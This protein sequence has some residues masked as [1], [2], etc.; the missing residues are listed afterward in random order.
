MKI[1]KIIFISYFSV[2]GLSLL[3]LLI[4]SFAFNDGKYSS[5]NKNNIET[6]TQDLE[7]F[8][9]VFI[10]K[11]CK[12]LIQNTQKPELSYSHLKAL[13][14]IESVFKIKNDTLFVIST[15][16]NFQHNAVTFSSSNILSITTENCYIILDNMT[17]EA[18]RIDA[19][20]TVIDIRDDTK[21]KKYE[22]TLKQSSDFRCWNDFKGDELSIDM[23]NSK[24]YINTEHKLSKIKGQISNHSEIHLPASKNYQLDVDENSKLQIY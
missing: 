6:K 22:L 23:Q 8:E 17:Q 13:K 15:K 20:G 5:W 9:H 18:L 10:G 7:H 14:L 3:S 21:I 19:S 12:V 11:G 4:V 24:L 1:S 16:G 2:I